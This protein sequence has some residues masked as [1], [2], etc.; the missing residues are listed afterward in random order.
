MS[1][2]LKDFDVL[3]PPKRIARIGG[4]NIDVT[5]VPARA[6]L[7]FISFSKKYNV[8]SMDSMNPGGFDPGMIDSILEVIEL[9]CRR[10]S[11]KITKE[12]LLDN[13]DIKVLME[14]IQ[15]VFAGMKDMS[16][17]EPAGDSGKNLESG[18]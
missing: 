18:T 4:E 2:L 6:A 8:D 12:W 15:Y 13:V 5:I 7:K 1:D 11:E 10:S 3:S 16:T 14:F 17:G 9:I